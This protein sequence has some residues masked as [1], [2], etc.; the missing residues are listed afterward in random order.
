MTENKDEIDWE[1]VLHGDEDERVTKDQL[2]RKIKQMKKASESIPKGTILIQFFDILMI[3]VYTSILV[4]Q[5]G[6]DYIIYL[7]ILIAPTIIIIAHD[8]LMIGKI[9]RLT[10]G[11]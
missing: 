1:K 6:N 7:F 10:R 11:E 8:I 5:I 9:R 3:L 2:I 4:T